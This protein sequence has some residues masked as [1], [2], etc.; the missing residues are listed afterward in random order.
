MSAML[1]TAGSFVA[2]GGRSTESEDA[3]RAR[4]D[5]GSTLSSKTLGPC[6]KV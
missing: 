2:V 5:D 6:T 3:S 1:R 4:R